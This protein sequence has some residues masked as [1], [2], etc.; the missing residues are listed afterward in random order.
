VPEAFATGR[1]AAGYAARRGSPD[2]ERL[3]LFD[4]EGIGPAAGM[5]SSADDLAKFARW[6]LRLRAAGGDRVL[7]ASTLREMQR[8]HWVDPDWKTTWGLGFNV[9]QV[10][11]T[12][13]ARH[14]GNCPGYFTEFGVLP[15]EELG[16]VV[17]TNAIGSDVVVYARK[18]AALLGQAVAA[19]AKGCAELPPRDPELDRYVGVYDSVWG[20]EAIVLWKD[21]LAAVE[22]GNTAVE[23]D[24]W[25]QPLKHIE[26]NVFRR[27]RA[28]DGS[29]GEEWVF[30]V[31]GDGQV[32]SVTSHS[33]PMTRVR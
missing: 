30:A 16:I 22:L 5:A 10:D 25:I 20:R 15:E 33:F 9:S 31:D 28:D 14:G 3:P 1:L 2:R 21:G 13:W 6:Q 24:D 7:R 32:V 23:L 29:L 4:V 26:G 27:V 11:G 19:A 8:V 18:A 17:L 12:T